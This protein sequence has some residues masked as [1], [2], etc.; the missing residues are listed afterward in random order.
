MWQFGWSFHCWYLVGVFVVGIWLELSLLEFAWSFHCWSL[1]GAFI[2]G[3]YPPRPSG[4]PPVE[5]NGMPSIYA[6]LIENIFFS[7]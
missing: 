6:M 1:L 2:V 4:T 5:G 3:V 7:P